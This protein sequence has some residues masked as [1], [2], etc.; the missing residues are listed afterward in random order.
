MEHR[1]ND[2]LFCRHANMYVCTM[3]ICMYVLI[4]FYISYITP[5]SHGVCKVT[6]YSA[7]GSLSIT[8]ESIS[9]GK[10]NSAIH[11]HTIRLSFNFVI[12]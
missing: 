1:N 8:N 5:V 12:Q 10:S 11:N 4:Y 7:I 2:S 3:Y 6:C 9:E